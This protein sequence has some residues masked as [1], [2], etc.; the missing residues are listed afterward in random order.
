VMSRIG[1]HLC[2]DHK[3][4]RGMSKPIDQLPSGCGNLFEVSADVF[5]MCPR[6]GPVADRTFPL[7]TFTFN[8]LLG[9]GAMTIHRM[10]SSFHGLFP[11]H[12]PVAPSSSNQTA[13]SHTDTPPFFNTDKVTFQFIASVPTDESLRH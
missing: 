8:S 7:G 10:R 3:G 6:R 2:I 11:K 1:R 12:P 5:K 13:S 4:V 9:F